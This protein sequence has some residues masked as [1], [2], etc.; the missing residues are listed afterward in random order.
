MTTV[1]RSLHEQMEGR[2]NERKDGCADTR[3]HTR[4]RSLRR[5]QSSDAQ[6]QHVMS[7]QSPAVTVPRWR[8]AELAVER[9][10]ADGPAAVVFVSFI[11]ALRPNSYHI[12]ITCCS[13]RQMCRQMSEHGAPITW[14][15]LFHA[16]LLTG[17][18]RQLNSIICIL[19]KIT[20]RRGTSS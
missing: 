3:T 14:L 5:H 16:E 18:S 19:P 7:D 12:R 4:M 17:S 11:I 10:V 1:R 9:R 15:N 13:R 2:T 6:L 20:F 8:A